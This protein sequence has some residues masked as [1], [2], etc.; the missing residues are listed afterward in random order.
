MATKTTAKTTR[1]TRSTKTTRSRAASAS[2][3][4]REIVIPEDYEPI[5]MWG[6]FGYEI[7]FMI[8]VVGWITCVAFA[9][10]AQNYNLRN[11]ARSQF[12]LLIIYVAIVCIL[13]AFGFFAYIAE[14]TG[15]I[16]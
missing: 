15:V 2:H 7:L 14:A 11:F 3:A 10:M 8:P 4:P 6:Y 9:F 12:C 5:S 16:Q 13:A 1:N